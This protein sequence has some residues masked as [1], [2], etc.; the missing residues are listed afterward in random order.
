M[1]DGKKC[2]D[3]GTDTIMEM[4][5]GEYMCEDC[6]VELKEADFKFA[7]YK[8][9]LV[10][11]VEDK[12]KLKVCK[13]D[14]G[15]GDPVQIVTNAKYLEVDWKVVVATEGAM[16]PAGADA[17]SG[18]LVAKANVGGTPSFGMLCDCPM[19]GWKG[20][21]AG[22]VVKLDDGE[23]GKTPPAERPT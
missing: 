6:G 9:G 21:A 15:S 14:V 8:I 19:L 13:V 3:C 5:E 1:A 18:T 22:Q 7:N 16:V 4:E 23:I 12:G 11:E 10:K 2:P 20:G 17:E